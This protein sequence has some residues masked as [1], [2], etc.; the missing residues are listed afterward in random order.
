MTTIQQ[1]TITKVKP[2]SGSNQTRWN[3]DVNGA[4]FG[5]IWT[6]TAKGEKHFF[7]AKPLI[8]SYASFDTY[9][10]AE[11]YMRGQI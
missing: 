6:F 10:E 1:I 3:I 5:A 4:P 9:A 11:T 2:V 7:H 8:G